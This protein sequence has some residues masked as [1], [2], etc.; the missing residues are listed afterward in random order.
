[1]SHQ[2]LLFARLTQG[3]RGTEH[4]ECVRGTKPDTRD[5]NTLGMFAH[6]RDE[7]SF[8]SGVASMEHWLDLNA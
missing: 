3:T 5:A 8:P 2:L 7:I 6:P 4:E 1:M